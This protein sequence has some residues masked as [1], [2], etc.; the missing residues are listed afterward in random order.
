VVLF[1]CLPV[2]VFQNYISKFTKFSAHIR[3]TSDGNAICYVLPVLWIALKYDMSSATVYMNTYILR[4]DMY[5]C[6][7][8]VNRC[9]LQLRYVKY[10]NISD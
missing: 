8:H 5:V 2:R 9:H 1:V 6:C 10:Y 4:L 7:M 3:Y